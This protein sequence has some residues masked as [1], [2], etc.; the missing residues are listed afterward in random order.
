MAKSSKEIV[1]TNGVFDILHAG[2]VDYLEKAASLGDIL[3]LG[4]NSD[5]SVKKNKGDKRPIIDYR[6]RA[7]LLA[8]LDCVDFIVP[9][10][11][12]TPIKLIEAIR[13]AILVK[14]ADYKLNEIV[15]ADF[16]RLNGGKVVRMRLVPGISTS[17][18]IRRIR[19]LD[20]DSPRRK[21][22]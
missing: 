19:S 5:A 8:A 4:L 10:A 2:H 18:I 16:V 7:R 1:F 12:K 14:G 20:S 11:E 6:H 22:R 13:P 9:L 17:E 15:G 21:I 3:V